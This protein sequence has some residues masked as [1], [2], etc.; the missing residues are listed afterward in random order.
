MIA[1]RYFAGAFLA[2]LV[3]A[4]AKPVS[5]QTYEGRELVKAELIADTDAIVPGQA[6]TAGLLLHGAALAYLLEIFR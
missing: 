3:V 1:R 6:L 5:A 4:V 2:L